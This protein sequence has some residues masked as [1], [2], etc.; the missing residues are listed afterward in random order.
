M[1]TQEVASRYYELIQKGQ[2]ETVLNELYSPDIISLEPENDSQVPLRVEGIDAC[3]QKERQFFENIE[4]M[5]GG[6]CHEPIVSNYHFACSMGMDVTYKGKERR[7]K[8][9]IG[10]F[11][12]ENGKIVKEQYFYDDFK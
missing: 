9:Q 12:V 7:Q 4:T 5:H 10:V 6:F 2:N 3:K 1:T 11:E 8:D